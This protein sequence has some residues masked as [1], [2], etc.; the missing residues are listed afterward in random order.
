M[1]T[2]IIHDSSHY[3]YLSNIASTGHIQSL[4]RHLPYEL[5][6]LELG[7]PPDTPPIHRDNRAVDV[8]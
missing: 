8:A 4:V 5:V 6:A 2:S 7:P 1:L 3:S